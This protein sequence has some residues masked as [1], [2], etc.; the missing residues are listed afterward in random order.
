MTFEKVFDPIA[1]GQLMVRL[2]ETGAEVEAAQRM[3]YHIFCEEMGGK[4]NPE[5]QRQHR[6]FDEYDDVC[7]H[8]LVLDDNKVVGTYRLI[9][10]E[11]IKN[12]GHFYTETEYDL[13]PIKNFAGPVL[14]LGRSCVEKQYRTRPVI[15]LLWQGIGAFIAAKDIGLMFGCASFTGDDA[16]KHKLALSYLYHYHLAPEDIRPRAL[17]E[18]YV[19]MDTIPKDEISP[20]AAIKEMPPLIKAYLRLNGYVGD[21]AVLDHAYNTTDVSIIVR[22][23]QIKA[24]YVERYVPDGE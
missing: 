15:Q 8:V 7:H 10:R 14:E 11:S 21:G 12:I 18:L 2:A 1:S 9:T 13:G 23:D 6:D 4:A 22:T 19:N 5:V 24:K 20:K 3:R 16:A 17:P